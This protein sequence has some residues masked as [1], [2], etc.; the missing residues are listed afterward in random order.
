MT[1][2]D[3]LPDASRP[4]LIARLRDT[5]DPGGNLPEDAAEWAREHTAAI[6][7][8]EAEL[9]AAEVREQELRLTLSG[10]GEQWQSMREAKD[11]ADAAC[12]R[13]TAERNAERA[14]V[15][16][17]IAEFD[18]PWPHSHTV[19]DVVHESLTW[20]IH[21]CRE[22]FEQRVQAAEA[23]RDQLREKVDRFRG[24]PA[25]RLDWVFE[26]L[27]KRFPDPAPHSAQAYEGRFFLM[28][29]NLLVARD[30]MQAKADAAMECLNRACRFYVAWYGTGEPKGMEGS[31]VAYE[32]VT[33]A[34][35]ALAALTKEQ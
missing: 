4:A 18:A 24:M 34:R 9:V 33:F 26:E 17:V 11:A 3:P 6:D 5:F 15:D 8:I 10:C 16:I 35:E 2:G 30:Q 31:S 7:A 22:S 23:A 21:K 27:K 28:L 20:Q 1:P 29:D 19:G 13:L 32:L 14:R 12:Q 25:A